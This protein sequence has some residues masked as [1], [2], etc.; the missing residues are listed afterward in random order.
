[1]YIYCICIIGACEGSRIASIFEEPGFGFQSHPF[2][3]RGVFFLIGCVFI[4][5]LL[6][7][8]HVGIQMNHMYKI[9]YTHIYIYI[10]LYK[11]IYRIMQS[12]MLMTLKASD[13]MAVV[14]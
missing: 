9:I 8:L 5:A 4:K 6:R 2:G 3:S 7:D 12:E 1:M 11:L 14:Q 13:A 10:Y